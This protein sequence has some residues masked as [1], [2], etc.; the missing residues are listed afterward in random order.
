[1][2]KFLYLMLAFA[3]A[4]PLMPFVVLADS[5]EK[6]GKSYSEMHVDPASVGSK[7]IS[8][9]SGTFIQPWLYNSFTE[10]EWEQEIAEW[11]L[12]GIEYIIMGDVATINTNDF[13]VKAAYPTK[14]EGATMTGDSLTKLFEKCS[15]N[16]IKL[17]LGTGNTEGGWG[18]TDFSNSANADVFKKVCTRFADIAEDVYNLY[19]DEYPDT[20]AGF[21]FVPELYNTSQVDSPASRKRYV[22]GLT[23]GMDILLD[24]I[25]EI[26]P[27]IPFFMSPYVN[28]FGGNWVSKD[29]DN[30][31]TFWS[32]F[33]ASGS[34]R[35]GDVLIPQDSCGAGG[36]DSAH[37]EDMTR[38]YRRGVDN[39]GKDIKLWSNC[40]IFIQPKD[41]EETG[42][43][44]WSSM[45]VGDMIEHFYI[46]SKYVDR[47]FTFA[48]PHYIGTVT[49]VDGYYDT[50]INYLETGELD[51]EPPKAPD[52]FRTLFN[53]VSG[54]KCL[55]VYWSGMYDNYGIHRINI[56]KN[57]E[58]FTFRVPERKGSTGRKSYP[59]TF[60]DLTY[61]E[62]TAEAVTYEFEAIDCAGNV[63]ERVK[64]LVEPGSVPNG[65]KLGSPY[66]GPIDVSDDASKAES[67][68]VSVASVAESTAAAESTASIGEAADNTGWIIAACGAAAAIIAAVAIVIG[69]RKKK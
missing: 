54:V 50:Y 48:Y 4:L 16:G 46:V 43:T 52:T 42:F 67:S 36:C 7:G 11:K 53:N 49:T 21:Y 37:L 3:L 29:Y 33:F 56:Y 1:M 25:T 28:L 5:N 9:M 15:A 58:F 47:I 18:Y 23:G 24:K 65:V 22:D 41:L 8:P 13:S 20:F 19:Y 57:G 63:S 55:N 14:L 27:S 59:N 51:S 60:Y 6:Q 17:I 39:C 35:D 30:L 26:N 68:E 34:F 10:L 32:E 61:T 66:K 44:T 62:D 2:K 31:A 38:A 12:L 64:L 40:E 45:P 69:R